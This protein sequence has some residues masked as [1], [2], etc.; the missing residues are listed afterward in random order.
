MIFRILF[1][2]PR[3][4]QGKNFLKQRTIQIN[5]VNVLKV[6]TTDSAGKQ[7]Q[8]ETILENAAFAEDLS[9]L[10]S[11]ISRSDAFVVAAK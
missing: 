10:Y 11:V 3:K 8:Q 1:N 7:L 2:R 9:S 4:F 6:F 5:T